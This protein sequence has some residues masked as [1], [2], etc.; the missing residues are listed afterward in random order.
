MNQNEIQKLQNT[1]DITTK[2]FTSKEQ[3]YID[4]IAQLEEQNDKA[5]K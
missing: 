4:A 1:I 3:E 2:D 5:E